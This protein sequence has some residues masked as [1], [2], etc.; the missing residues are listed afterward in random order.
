MLLE[1]PDTVIEETSLSSDEIRMELA[2]W[3]YAMKRL[4][5]GQARKLAGATV[6]TFQKALAEKDLYLHFDLEDL[7]NEFSVSSQ[8]K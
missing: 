6:I 2:I 1:I 5:F 3:L 7:K 8:V 4:T